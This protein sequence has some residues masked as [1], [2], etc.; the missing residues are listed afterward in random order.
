LRE[1]LNEIFR[2]RLEKGETFDKVQEVRLE[3]NK[4]VVTWRNVRPLPEGG[5]FFENVWRQYR[6]NKNVY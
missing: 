1:G 6:E 4:C 3:N 5:D 2:F